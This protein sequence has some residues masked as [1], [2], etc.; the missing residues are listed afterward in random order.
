MRSLASAEHIRRFMEAVGRGAKNETRIYFTGGTSAVLLGWRDA[1][2]DIDLTIQ[3]DDDE[4]LR[5]LPALKDQLELNIELASPAHF[6]PELPGWEER[7]LFI[8]QHGS[9]TFLHYDFYSQALSKI[10][11]GHAQDL[12]DVEAMVRQ[13][14]VEPDRLRA[15]FEA[16]VPLLYRY[17]AVDPESLRR[18]LDEALEPGKRP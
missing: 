9:V 1:T 3:P 18:A 16:I 15:M 5:L 11:R 7:S 17:P 10:E 13:G 8:A 12:L 6:I 4:V 14:R 2:I